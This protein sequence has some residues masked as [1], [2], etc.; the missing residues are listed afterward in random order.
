[1]ATEDKCCSIVPYFQV[2]EG[3]MANFKSLCEEFVAKSS[4]EEGCI[5]YG[6]SF[7]GN[8]VH[9]RE[10]YKNGEGVLAHLDNVGE[11]I[12]RALEISELL[13]I[14]IHG[15][16]EE[17]QKLREPLTGLNPQYFVLEYGFRK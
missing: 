4:T 6:F 12:G 10:A 16:E 15:P 5:Y 11:L 3:E 2:N 17:L 13:R 9:C 14:E 8:Q 7:N 1:M